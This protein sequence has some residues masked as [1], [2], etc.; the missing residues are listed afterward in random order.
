MSRFYPLF[1]N[2]TGRLCVVIGGGAVAERK[3]A[4]LLDA[5]ARVRVVSPEA[6]LTLRHLAEQGRIE[7][8]VESY[9]SAHLEGAYLVFAATS[10]RAV[11]AQVAND[12]AEVG[13]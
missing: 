4:G 12:A 7:L 6:T 2:I 9:Q 13:L 10:M 3:V 8:V 11:N 1:L 5:G